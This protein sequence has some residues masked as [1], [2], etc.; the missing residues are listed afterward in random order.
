MTDGGPS[1]R[2]RVILLVGL[3]LVGLNLRPAITTVPPLLETIRADIAISYAAASLLT[4][5]PVFL[6]G[7][8]ALL[9]PR[10][11]ARVGREWAVF[12]AMAVITAAT[13]A[14]LFGQIWVVLVISTVLVGVGIA[15]GQTIL[16]AVVNA[17]FPDKVAFATGLYTAA[18]AIGAALGSMFAIPLTSRFG[19]WTVGLAVWGVLGLVGL[20]TWLPLIRNAGPQGSANTVPRAGLLSELPLSDPLAWR[21]ILFLG[22]TANFFF[23]G[24]TWLPPRFVDVGWSE[25]SA[26]VLLTLFILIGLLGMLTIS[27]V[28]DRLPDRRPWIALMGCCVLVG[29]VA[30]GIF[31]G[32]IAWASVG[33]FGVGSGGLFTVALML[34]ADYAPD[35]EATSRVSAM[36]FAGGYLIAGGGPY[37]V[38]LA[39]D[40]GFG[41]RAVF[42]GI[43]TTA[44]ALLLVAVPLSPDRSPVGT[45]RKS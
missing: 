17:Y 35:P 1:H 31:P 8:F 37:L 25:A 21:L 18:L 5:I 6:M 19:D 20:A 26:G 33:L 7:V 2:F 44:V 22:L 11:V 28:G 15:V 36:V 34:P 23:V 3:I 38:G 14:R 30:I 42:L 16:P 29:T 13:I 45:A 43:A 27:A 12:W 9:T 24:I 10:I 39:L 41:Y 32:W 40:A 4:A